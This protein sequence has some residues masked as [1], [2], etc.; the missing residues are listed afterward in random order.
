MPGRHD[1]DQ[2]LHPARDQ[3]GH[4]IQPLLAFAYDG[5][6]PWGESVFGRGISRQE[7]AQGVWL[8]G[9][10]SADRL[11]EPHRPHRYEKLMLRHGYQGPVSNVTVQLQKQLLEALALVA[12]WDSL[13]CLSSPGTFCRLSRWD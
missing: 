8:V 7:H 11:R 5:A 12:S 3:I 13:R 1:R 9:E 10:A 4:I 6:T 2:P